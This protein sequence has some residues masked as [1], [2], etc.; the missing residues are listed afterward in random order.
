MAQRFFQR[1][2]GWESPSGLESGWAI[3][4]ISGRPWERVCCI[5]NTNLAGFL[6]NNF[7]CEKFIDCL[8]IA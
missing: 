8:P 6:E 7:G 4:S 3:W 5:A 2:I 1:G